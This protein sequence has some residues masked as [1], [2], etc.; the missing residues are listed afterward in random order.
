MAGSLNSKRGP[1]RS[2]PFPGREEALKDSAN[3][4]YRAGSV[5]FR[6]SYGQAAHP[7]RQDLGRPSGGR[8]AGRHLPDLHRPPPRPRGDLAAGVRG[9]APVRPQGARAGEDA[10]A[11][12]TTTCRPPTAT[13]PIRIRK[14]RR[15]S[16]ISPRT[17]SCSGSNTTT[18]STSGRASST[19][20]APSRASPC[21]A[22]RWSAAT[23]IPRPTARS[24][25]SP[26]AS[27]RP[28]SSTCW[29]RRR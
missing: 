24:A 6:S 18:S 26:T 23:A 5:E 4:I 19:S 20:S 29:R 1:A 8:A 15:R 22:S 9:A 27:A 12:S 16:S 11:S 17:P 3:P 21:R 28:R 2:R 13:C 14:A 10:A 7:L 25:R